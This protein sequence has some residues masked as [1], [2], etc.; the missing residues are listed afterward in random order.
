MVP[1][2]PQLKPCLETGHNFDHDSDIRF[3]VD[4]HDGGVK[5]TLARAA[6]CLRT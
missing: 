6:N 2:Y 4:R 1:S 5:F 3:V